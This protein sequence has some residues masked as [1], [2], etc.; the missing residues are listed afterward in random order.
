MGTP[1]ILR[2]L[3]LLERYDK[4]PTVIVSPSGYRLIEKCLLDAAIHAHLVVQDRPLGMGNAVLEYKRSPS[5]DDT[6]DLLLVWG[7]LPFI[8]VTTVEVTM[9]KHF[10]SHNDFTL[11][12][13]V[14]DNAYTVVD[15]TWDGAVYGITETREQQSP[16]TQRAERDIG[17]FLFKIAPVFNMLVEELPE[18]YG[19]KSGEHGFLYIVQHLVQR[20]Y[21]VEALPIAQ[22]V[23]VLSLNTVAD[24][25]IIKSII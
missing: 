16:K 13:R 22:Q 15:R 8:S 24:R 20:G 5:F 14:V 1:I 12:T 3:S 10:S 17:L 25:H 7:D 19:G 2:I 23:E 21:K 9:A 6:Q 4:N 11:P 18:K